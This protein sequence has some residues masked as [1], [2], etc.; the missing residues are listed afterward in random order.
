VAIG[1]NYNTF[2]T[3]QD[4]SPRGAGIGQLPEIQGGVLGYGS[5]IKFEA[6][7][8]FSTTGTPTL[9]LG[10]YIGTPAGAPTTVL[11]ENTAIAMPSSVTSFPW[12]LEWHG[13]VVQT[14]VT[15]SVVG[16]G[17]LQY[18]TSLTVLTSLEIPAT[19][20]LRTIVWDTTINRAVGVCATWSVSSA[21]N[22]VRVYTHY[23][24]IIT[25]P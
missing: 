24:T 22:N 1:P 15:G 18:G 21:S 20:A 10:F 14:G 19:L 13:I 6:D 7:G 12:H 25:G 23:G 16:C 3:R 9:S 2:T 4:V 8:E 17:S 5:K 11:A